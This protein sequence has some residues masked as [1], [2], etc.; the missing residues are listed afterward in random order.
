MKKEDKSYRMLFEAV[1]RLVA[2]DVTRQD[3]VTTVEAM[4]DVYTLLPCEHYD[5]ANEFV[6]SLISPQAASA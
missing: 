3:I 5:F 1:A 4:V 6:A 2:A